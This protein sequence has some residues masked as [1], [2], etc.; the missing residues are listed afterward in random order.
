MWLRTRLVAVA[1]ASL[2]LLVPVTIWAARAAAA[3]L[4]HRR[5]C[6]R[7]A[8]RIEYFLASAAN[9][10]D[11]RAECAALEGELPYDRQNREWSPAALFRAGG[12]RDWNDEAAWHAER[13]HVLRLA[14]GQLA[15][16]V[17]DVRSHLILPVPLD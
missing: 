11:Q 12:F 10:D 9:H 13:A 2:A 4:A 17:N 8:S 16:E 15:R 1:A 3:E 7:L 5:A 6:R 14:A